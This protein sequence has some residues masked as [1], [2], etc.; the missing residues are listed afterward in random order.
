RTSSSIESEEVRRR[1]IEEAY[2]GNVSLERIDLDPFVEALGYFKEQQRR[3]SVDSDITPEQLME[4]TR[5]GCLLSAEEIAQLMDEE[6]ARRKMQSTLL[7]DGLFGLVILS[8][9]VMMGLTTQGVVN[10]DSEEAQTFEIV[11]MSL[12]TVEFLCHW[13]FA[14]LEGLT[15][16]RALGQLMRDP[17]I[18]FDLLCIL[19]SWLDF[20]MTYALSIA[21]GTSALAVLRVL[22]LMRLLRLVRLLKILQQLWL[23]LSSMFASLRVLFWA[24]AMLVVICYIFGILIFTLSKDAIDQDPTVAENWGGVA[25]SMLSLLQ[26]ATYNGADIIRRR[27]KGSDAYLFM[28]VMF[29]FM[30]ICSLG[31]INLIVG[32]LLTAVLERGNQDEMFENT[33]MKLR[34]HRALR[35]LRF[36]LVLHAE[37]TL[38]K[39]KDGSDGS[40]LVSRRILQGW[41]RGPDAELTA[42][43][44]DDV[45][46][47][48]ALQEHIQ[49]IQTGHT[50]LDA[51]KG[52][53]LGVVKVRKKGPC[54]RC[55]GAIRERFC[56]P[57][58]RRYRKWRNI[59]ATKKSP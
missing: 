18:L 22:R 21:G 50:N 44:M 9:G 38:G 6:D 2:V 32:V 34:Q 51:L 26:I 5:F 10:E 33:I 54:G 15:C 42:E 55:V 16:C 29:G 3:L 31:I 25:E 8:N 46:D 37:K 47:E 52:K 43:E 17:W 27:T 57:F 30:A 45:E 7:V 24:I 35:R 23:L 56:L 28:P 48:E 19:L 14:K 11:C 40:H 20:F 1:A 58:I 53:G 12:F 36:G 13:L 4:E 39:N 41:A 59:E 49:D